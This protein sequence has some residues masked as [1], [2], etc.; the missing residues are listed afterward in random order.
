MKIGF[1]FLNYKNYIDTIN[2]V[3]SLLLCLAKDAQVANNS[4]QILI[5]DNFSNNDSNIKIKFFI[6]K[7]KIKGNL[8][9]KLDISFL[10]LYNNHGYGAGNNIG[11]KR[12]FDNYNCD[13]VFVA[14]NDLL[15]N[16]VSFYDLTQ[17]ISEDDNILIGARLY[18]KNQRVYISGGAIFN[19]IS[20][21]SKNLH[22]EKP[23]K[24]NSNTFYISGAFIGFTKRIYHDFGGFAE[25]YFLY[26]EELDYFFRYKKAFNRLP[27]TKILESWIVE[28]EIGGSTGQSS[29]SNNKSLLSEYYSA[30]A[31]ILFAK[32]LMHFFL[33]SAIIYNIS[34][35]MHR[36]LKGM[37]KNSIAIFFATI[38][39][40]SNEKGIKH[41]YHVNLK[42]Y[43]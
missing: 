12:L 1:V 22:S 5:V 3:N 20:F 36:L 15:F 38:N 43:S 29:Y 35:A 26:F 19:K 32:D 25:N 27:N 21:R 4:V 11:L 8:K 42:W 18:D 23:Q 10:E 7:L 13:V 34:I 39:G 2:S 33:P 9:N 16:E 6:D 31:R 30:R 41:K 17:G 28:H 37:Y 24:T 40:L 14:N